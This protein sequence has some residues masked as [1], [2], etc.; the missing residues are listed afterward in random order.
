MKPPMP[1]DSDRLF[2]VLEEWQPQ[3]EPAP[4]FVAALRRRI[5]LHQHSTGRRLWRWPAW[6]AAG[7]TT[8][9]A[10]AVLVWW[11]R[12]QPVETPAVTVAVVQDLQM[13]NRNADLIENLDFLKPPAAQRVVEEQ[14]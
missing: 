12:P 14:N 7:A 9:A 8:A 1:E 5:A 6:T 3:L 11:T 2:A 10:L 13:W 4:G